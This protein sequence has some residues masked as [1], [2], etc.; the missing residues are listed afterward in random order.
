M[1][2]KCELSIALFGC[3]ESSLTAIKSINRSRHGSLKCIV[4][5]RKKAFNSDYV[6]LTSH[7]SNG[8]RIIFIEDVTEREITSI[9]EASK[10]KIGFCV[11]WSNLIPATIYKKFDLF[12][13]YHPSPLPIGRGRNPITWAIALGMEETASS[14][15]LICNKP[16][17]GDI[18]NQQSV[19]ISISDTARTLYDKLL[20]VLDVQIEEILFA[21]WNDK[22]VLKKQSTEL[23]TYWRKRD[24]ADRL[25]DF[26]MSSTS[27]YNLIRSLGPP[28]VYPQVLINGKRFDVVRAYLTSKVPEKFTEFG[29]VLAVS[30]TIITVR[31]SDG[32]VGIQLLEKN[33]QIN[34]GDYL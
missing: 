17:A 23:A 29:K 4:T 20:E 30:D 24:D 10:I 6:D 12:F 13:G 5:T 25:I 1:M 34:K 3:V 26:R 7:V 15:F 14:F 32:A 9:F 22:L 19:V 11:G 8:V 18:V 33:L 21:I 28:Y 27:I 2:S 16:D 31:T